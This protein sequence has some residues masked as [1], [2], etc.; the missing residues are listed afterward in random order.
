M[1]RKSSA[2]GLVVAQTRPVLLRAP[3]V[4]PPEPERHVETQQQVAGE[5]AERVTHDRHQQHQPDQ[6]RGPQQEPPRNLPCA[7]APLLVAIAVPLRWFPP[8][9]T[10]EADERHVT[11]AT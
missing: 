8:G 4:E 1:D 6:Q 2:L 9:V 10:D 7:V 5:L 3:A 11:E